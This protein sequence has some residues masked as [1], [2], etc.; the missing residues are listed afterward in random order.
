V[1]STCPCYGSTPPARVIGAIAG[2]SSCGHDRSIYLRI[3]LSDRC[4]PVHGIAGILAVE[5]SGCSP[6][7]N[8]EIPKACCWAWWHSCSPCLVGCRG[9]R[10]GRPL[11]PFG[12]AYILMG[13]Q[14]HRHAWRVSEEEE[15]E[16]L[17]NPRTWRVPA[18]PSGSL[19][20][21]LDS[22]HSELITASSSRT[23][24]TTLRKR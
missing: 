24:S 21:L 19:L 20:L 2:P 8:G 10:C 4:G 12:V 23:S 17:D 7:A 22:D 18:L 6:R 9:Q 3:S 11:P 1:A 14:S 13:R 15:L 16:G 5:A